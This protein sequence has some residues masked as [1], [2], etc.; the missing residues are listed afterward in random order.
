MDKPKPVNVAR[1]LWETGFRIRVARETKGLT[2]EQLA[3]RA[4]YARASIANIEAGKQRLP[5]HMLYELA[6][7]L[8]VKPTHL[9]PSMTAVTEVR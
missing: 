9:L 2:Q 6:V 5:L 4:G 8:D 7:A 3:E 1:L